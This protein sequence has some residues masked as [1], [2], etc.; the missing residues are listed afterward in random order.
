MFQM[1]LSLIFRIFIFAF[2]FWLLK[3]CLAYLS[4]RQKQAGTNYGPKT[5][6]GKTV[7]DPVCGMYMDPKLAL[8]LEAGRETYYFC[9]ED[10]KNKYIEQ[11][12]N[13]RRS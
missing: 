11:S 2:I 1:I 5:V 10:C 3:Y 8:P 6:T 13:V 12:R 7:K 9:S 4:R